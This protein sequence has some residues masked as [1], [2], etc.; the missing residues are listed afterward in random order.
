MHPS[1]VAQFEGTVVVMKI[2]GSLTTD[3]IDFA[4]LARV[5]FSRYEDAFDYLIF[6]SNL[7]AISFRSG[8]K[9]LSAKVKW[10]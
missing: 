9:N 7:P 3:T 8:L 10:G 1:V 2:P 4:E 5:F 6:L